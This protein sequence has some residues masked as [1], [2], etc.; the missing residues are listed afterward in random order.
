[1]HTR[2]PPAR[3]SDVPALE[4]A[5]HTRAVSAAICAAFLVGPI[6]GQPAAPLEFEVASVKA[7]PP[8]LGNRLSTRMSVDPAWLRYTNVSLRDVLK[9]AYGVQDDQIS[10]PEWL[11]V[12]RFDIVAKIPAGVP[13]DGVPRMLQALLA[14]RFKLALHR[15][16]KEARIYA[17]AVAKNGSGL[18][19]GLQKAESTSGLT[20]N[21]S[22]T[23]HHAAGNVTMA[24]F[25][26]YLAQQVG[27]VVLDQT[28]LG[29]P[30]AIALDWV[31]DDGANP[32]PATGAD[33]AAAGPSLFMAL[34]EQ[35]GLRLGAQRGP[36][37]MLVIDRAEKVPTEN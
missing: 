16:T 9:Q 18:P 13:K 29:G 7:A 5:I 6:W 14:D 2:H 28:G 27:R 8:Q 3:H 23:R 31:A 36:V 24:Q 26:D 22:R 34:Q 21:S 17:L 25:A 33:G 20:G 15:E 37:E 12:A 30:F 35:L 32:E 11:G 10:G 19:K 1:M 4:T